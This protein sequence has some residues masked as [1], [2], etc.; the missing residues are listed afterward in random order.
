[1]AASII[2]Y[3]GARA[4][5]VPEGCIGVADCWK[6]STGHFSLFSG[7]MG[8]DTCANVTVYGSCQVL[9][10]ENGR[11]VFGPVGINWNLH[12]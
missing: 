2:G 1:M 7:V 5:V 8:I 10:S 9:L 11:S 4:G 12:K 6:T 3:C